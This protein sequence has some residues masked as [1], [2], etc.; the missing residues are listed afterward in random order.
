M[1]SGCKL[2][3]RIYSGESSSWI[4]IK[5]MLEDCIKSCNCRLQEESV[6]KARTARLAVA[7]LEV[8]KALS[9]LPDVVLERII[10]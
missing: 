2:V 10:W 9:E 3:T 7:D 5:H 1:Y 6:V 4:C 8:R